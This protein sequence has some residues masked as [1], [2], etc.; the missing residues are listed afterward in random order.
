M[1]PGISPAKAKY[2]SNSKFTAEGLNKLKAA[3]I[4]GKFGEIVD[5]AQ[6]DSNAKYGIGGEGQYGMDA[7]EISSDKAVV[8]AAKYSP[9]KKKGCGHTGGKKKK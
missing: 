8:A 1:I 9:A 7:Q 4:G 5:N 6:P 2:N 3:N